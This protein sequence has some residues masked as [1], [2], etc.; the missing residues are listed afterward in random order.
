MEKP[1]KPQ[2][3]IHNMIE[4]KNEIDEKNKPLGMFLF[5]QANQFG[6]NTGNRILDRVWM[7]GKREL[8]SLVD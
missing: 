6:L 2:N 4:A 7:N 8:I 3:R 5:A 1:T